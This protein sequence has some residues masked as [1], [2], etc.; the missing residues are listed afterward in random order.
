[1]Q[2]FC[3]TIDEFLLLWK[4]SKGNAILTSISIENDLQRLQDYN[5]LNK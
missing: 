1:M 5:T 2:S 4:P 3:T